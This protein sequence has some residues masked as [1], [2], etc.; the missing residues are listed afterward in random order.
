MNN[1]NQFTFF[2]MLEKNV[3]IADG[4]MGTMLYQHGVF[5]NTCYDELNLT[6]PDLVGRIHTEYVQAGADFIETNTFGANSIKLAQ[7]GLAEKT[8]HINEKAVE[9]AKSSTGANVLVAGAMGPLTSRWLSKK[10]LQSDFAQAFSQQARSLARAGADFLILETFSNLNEILFA[11]NSIKQVTDLP[12]IAQL[13][14]T[15][16]NET[17]YGDQ[18]QRSILK[19]SEEN[20]IILL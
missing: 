16:E 12:V 8:E 1:T 2:D 6:R 11:I 19:I 13:T 17:A 4:A 9:I 20:N 18:L 15:E 14:V 3:V 10:N 5:V 7:F